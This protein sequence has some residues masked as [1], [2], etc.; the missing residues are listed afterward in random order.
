MTK[1][2]YQKIMR[3]LSHRQSDL[4]V[5]VEDV[6]KPHNLSAILRSCDAVGIGEVRAVN[7]TGGIPTF[8]EISASADKW[9]NLTVNTDLTESF[10]EIRSQDMKI[11]AAHLSE[12][13]VDYR[14]IDYTQPTCILMGNEKRGVS[15]AAAA[16]ADGHII[17]PMMGMIQSLNVSVAAAIILSEAQ[18]QRQ[19][20][21]MYESTQLS[22]DVIDRQ[23]FKWLYAREAKR[24][25]E[26]GLDY[27]ALDEDGNIINAQDQAE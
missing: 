1:S 15:E 3:V 12:E 4:T 11:W 27:P 24:L 14:E 16:R 2:R 23:C 22:Q 7:P 13:A 26:L 9:V 20:K 8:N 25:D 6:Y 21:G 19:Q 17:I 10:E 5:L 18:R